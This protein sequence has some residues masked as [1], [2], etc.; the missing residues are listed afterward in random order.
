MLVYSG[1]DYLCSAFRGKPKKR[2]YKK[3]QGRG[4]MGVTRDTDQRFQREKEAGVV[5]YENERRHDLCKL[6]R[7]D[8]LGT[9]G[10]GGT[11]K[12]DH[13]RD[14]TKFRVSRDTPGD[15]SEGTEGHYSKNKEGDLRF[16]EIC[17]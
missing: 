13:S 3:G 2:V 9:E 14:N 17:R 1:F 15:P 10:R 4:D 7:T 16:F 11:G 8:P 5:S 6:R 12:E